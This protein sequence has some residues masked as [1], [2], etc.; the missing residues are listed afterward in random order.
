VALHV[1]A[2]PDTKAFEARIP[3][4]GDGD[5]VLQRES[6]GGRFAEMSFG[7]RYPVSRY[8]CD[9]NAGEFELLGEGQAT[10][11]NSYFSFDEIKGGDGF[12]LDNLRVTY[13]AK[14][15]NGGAAFPRGA[16]A[17]GQLLDA[18]SAMVVGF[19]IGGDIE[20]PVL[21]QAVGTSID[22]GYIAER[23]SDLELELYKVGDGGELNLLASNRDWRNASNS[24]TITLG[25]AMAQTGAIDTLSAS[26]GEARF[27]GMLGNGKYVAVLRSQNG[28]IGTAMLEVYDAR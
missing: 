25:D 16:R 26:G 11:W 9:S 15:I 13:A 19:E 5:V 23:A 21:L 24:S 22:S 10:D 12:G 17:M 7:S 4:A 18:D 27:L 1:E 8:R 28:S 14:S 20:L 3:L 6:S 2:A